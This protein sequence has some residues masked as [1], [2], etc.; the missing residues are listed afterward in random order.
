MSSHYE[1]IHRAIVA[2]IENSPSIDAKVIRNADIKEV[3]GENQPVVIIHDGEAMK[4]YEPLGGGLDVGYELIIEPEF[5]VQN[6]L[7]EDR[8]N[9]FDNLISAFSGALA[10]D[11]TLGG[12]VQGIR[13][14]HPKTELIKPDGVAPIK[15]GVMAIRGEYYISTPI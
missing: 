13:W 15:A 4:T 9:I 3:I 1:Q 7:R 2:L 14:G 11:E 8:D 10:S 5:Y 12:L 6:N